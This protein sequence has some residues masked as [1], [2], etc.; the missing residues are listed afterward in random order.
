MKALSSLRG[1]ASACNH[2][3]NHRHDPRQLETRTNARVRWVRGW[4][5]RPARPMMT[6]AAARAGDQPLGAAMA[7]RVGSTERLGITVITA[8]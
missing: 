7:E 6:N 4:D 5:A 3:T 2:T 8:E 1:R